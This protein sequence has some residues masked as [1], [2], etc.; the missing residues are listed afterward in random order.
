M[1]T[2]Q[3]TAQARR[4]LDKNLKRVDTGIA[5]PK[6]GWVRAIREA[7]GM[8][9]AQLGARMP[10]NRKSVRGIS[11]SAV[12]SLEKKEAAGTVT[13][14]SL[15]RAA[16]A[17]DCTLVYALVPNE[18]LETTVQRQ[19]RTIAQN[20]ETTTRRTMQLE[21]QDYADT[22]VLAQ[23]EALIGTNALWR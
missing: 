10:S 21:D 20:I 13:L 16:E 3:K 19:A 9:R 8:T 15:R 12:Q 2:K 17:L 14:G 6:T 1:N 18:T 4:I 7:L 22:D 11:T 5:V 23:A